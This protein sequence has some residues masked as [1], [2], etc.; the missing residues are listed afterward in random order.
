MKQAWPIN[1]FALHGTGTIIELQAFSYYAKTIIFA[2]IVTS[3]WAVIVILTDTVIETE[4]SQLQK[5]LQ[6]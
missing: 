5:I 1:Y 3:Q 2:H 6:K 4:G